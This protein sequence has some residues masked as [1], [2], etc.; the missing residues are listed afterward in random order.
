MGFG[1][2]AHTA[3]GHSIFSQQEA[4][5]GATCLLGSPSLWRFSSDAARDV[6]VPLGQKYTPALLQ[7]KR[8]LPLLPQSLR[9]IV[10]QVSNPSPHTLFEKQNISDGKSCHR[11]HT[12]TKPQS[13]KSRTSSHT[14]SSLWELC[15]R[16]HSNPKLKALSPSK[17]A[18]CRTPPRHRKQQ[19]PSPAGAPAPA[20]GIVA[21]G[22]P[23]ETLPEEK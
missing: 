9:K 16:K 13:H 11:S 1:E 15:C 18:P 14:T 20:H 6:S 2:L 19:V 22:H 17:P 7:T 21:P 23:K 12:R 8:Y 10:F 4:H 5:P 3:S